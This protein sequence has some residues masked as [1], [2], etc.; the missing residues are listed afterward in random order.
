MDDN[1]A[2]R[3]VIFALMGAAAVLLPLLGHW[4]RLAGAWAE[5]ER[6][7]TLSH[8]GPAVWGSCAVEGGTERYVGLALAGHLRLRRYDAGRDHLINL[9][10]P[11]ANVAALDGACTGSF[12]FAHRDGRLVG[13]FRGSRFRLEDARMVPVERLAPLARAW[14]R[15]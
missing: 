2:V 15:L 1:D 14:Q 3:A 6:R 4:P 11:A 7:I 9:G 10:F 8:L 12:T 5:A 13:H